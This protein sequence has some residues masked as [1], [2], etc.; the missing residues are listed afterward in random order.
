MIEVRN[1]TK[2]YRVKTGRHY[3]FR[4]V[5]AVFPEGAN[6][7][8]IGPNGGGKSTFLR[9]LGGIDHPDSGEIATNRSFSW[10]LGLK[11]GFVNH[12]SGRENCRMVCNLYGLHPRHI[13]KQLGKIK[14]L[15]GIGEYFEEPVKY[16]SSGMGSRLGFALSMSFDFDYF[17]I[18]EITAVG[19]AQFK[20]LAKHALQEKARRSKV[21]MVSHS[22]G[23]IKNFCDVGVV[24]RDG[25][26][27][28][29]E[30]LDEAIRSYLPQTPDAEDDFSELMREA[31]L[32]E[33][34]L[35]SVPIPADLK[36]VATRVTELRETVMAKLGNPRH[37]IVGNECDVY[38]AL[39]Q[40]H[41]KL[42]LPAEAERFYRKAVEIDAYHLAS[43]Q[44][45]AA[46]AGSRH[47]SQAEQTALAAAEKI[48][49]RNLKTKLVRAKA[50]I[51]AGEPE[52]A[53]ALLEDLLKKNPKHATAWSLRAKLFQQSNRIE[54]ALDSQIKAVQSGPKNA[55][56]HHQLKQLLVA[57][58]QVAL[59]A[60]SLYKARSLPE[61]SPEKDFRST[62]K[63][64]RQIDKQIEV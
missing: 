27:S 3:V 7:G 26:L 28:V 22:M 23:D 17:L 34:N 61:S 29:Y 57:S 16:Y 39:G 20:E 49:P 8:I 46:L 60:R 52:E 35:E 44:Q 9:I 30:D 54:E 1:L 48:D 56:F 42:G 24:L 13:S 43:Q 31:N 19:D 47:D 53:L 32:A 55:T 38:A 62:L 2:S 36:K 15:S 11:G 25:H 21:I 45:L 50:K 63:L 14:E 58:G 41:Q 10:P 59:A 6:I 64:L 5:N 51:R 18:D 4:E 40:L 12:L 37:R 33:I